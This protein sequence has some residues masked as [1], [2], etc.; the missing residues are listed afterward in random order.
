MFISI[1]D[2]SKRS[3]S[4]EI[5]STNIGKVRFDAEALEQRKDHDDK[6]GRSNSFRRQPLSDSRLNGPS[7]NRTEKIRIKDALDILETYHARCRER[8][9]GKKVYKYSREKN[10]QFWNKCKRSVY[11]KKRTSIEDSNQR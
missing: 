9:N 11:M 4:S 3:G 5:R 10:D 6:D 2:E 1:L 8:C 7:K